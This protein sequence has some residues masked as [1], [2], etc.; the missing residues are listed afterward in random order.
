MS[1]YSFLLKNYPETVSKDQFYQICHISKKT[2]KYYLDNGFI[3]CK[4]SKKK[5]R[6]YQI[7]T[8]DI[9][10]FLED[11]DAN[12]SKYYL[13]N[14]YKNPFLPEEQRQHKRM[15]RN[16]NYKDSYKLK[17]ANEVNDYQKYLSQQFFE[18]PDMMTSQHLRQITG[19]SITVIISWCK[20]KKVRY[21]FYRNTYLMQKKSVIKYLCEREMQDYSHICGTASPQI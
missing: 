20:D 19:H 10:S 15:P 11:R 12:P 4:D 13:P 2:A 14:H 7:K 3:P 9:V 5:T 6:C 18:Y 1:D 17:S 21:I 16:G 8:K